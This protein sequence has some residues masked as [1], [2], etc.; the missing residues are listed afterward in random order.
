MMVT[1]KTYKYAPDYAVAPGESLR[2]AI[3]H[4]GMTQAEF[5]QRMGITVQSLSQIL[6]GEQAISC[7][8]AQKLEYVTGIS[9]KFWNNMEARYREQ[10]LVVS[11][12]RFA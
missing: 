5:A 6:S 8:T 1:N 10:L 7:E 11:R 4:L 2:E 9:S 3:E 12:L